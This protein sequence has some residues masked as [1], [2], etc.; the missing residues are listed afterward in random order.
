MAEVQDGVRLMGSL[1]DA[2][3]AGLATAIQHGFIFM[4]GASLLSLLCA[5]WLA[6]LR[7]DTDVA[8]REIG[9]VD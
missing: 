4:L 8:A 7:I 1:L 6:D 3:R 5:L 9:A 2:A